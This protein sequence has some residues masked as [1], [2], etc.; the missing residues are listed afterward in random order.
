[1]KDDRAVRRSFSRAAHR[2]FLRRLLENEVPEI[3]HG[4]V[5]IRAIAREPGA[6]GK[7]AVMATRPAWILSARVWE[8]KAFVFRL[9]LK[10]CTMKRSILFNGTPIRLFIFPKPS[11]RRVNGVYL[12]EVDGNR[13]A[14]VVVMEI[15]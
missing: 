11:A 14:T 13:T 2:N 12:N 4:I 7:V 5:E 3:Y 10:N 6:R 1:M 15:N 9:L 8:L